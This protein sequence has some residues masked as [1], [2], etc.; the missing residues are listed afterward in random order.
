M[1]APQIARGVAAA[2]ATVAALAFAA[3]VAHADSAPVQIA[4]VDSLDFGSPLTGQ[5]TTRD[6]TLT[7]STGGVLWLNTI[8]IG[9]GAP[10]EISFGYGTDCPWA[11]GFAPG[12]ADGGTCTIELHWDPL[13]PGSASPSFYVTALAA[14]PGQ[15][16]Q[17]FTSNVLH[18]TVAG[19][20]F[21]ASPE[22]I[23]FGSQALATLSSS[24]VVAIHTGSTVDRVRTRIDGANR[25]DF[26]VA[27]EDCGGV[28]AGGSC[29][30]LVRFAPDGLG[31][32]TATLVVTDPSD[33][34]THSVALSGTGVPVP[35]GP[36]GP[37]GPQGDPGAPG[38]IGPEGPQGIQGTQGP[39]GATGPQGPQGP[40]GQVICRNTAAARALCT[41]AFAP[42][43]WKAA[44]TATVAR[45]TLLRG[46][47]VV[48]HGR[49]PAHR[50]VRI[51]LP[52]RLPGGHYVLKV[53][54]GRTVVRQ[55]VTVA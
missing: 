49:R 1:Q 12:L 55:A 33:G 6:L 23:D 43:T 30:I 25:G 39:K 24:H 41:V 32:R 45:Y 46:G 9:D 21:E 22:G 18:L 54:V 40:A 37:E 52:R 16:L 19:R 53:R 28:P 4:P 38:A 31:A 34:E 14:E 44:A 26:V 27:S 8:S 36:Q 35:P 47:R 17:P 50:R 5:R 3:P 10:G 42:G 48:A 20:G 2:A 11:T 29:E 15:F 7:N 13:R 51:R